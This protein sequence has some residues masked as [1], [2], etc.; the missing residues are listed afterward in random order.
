MEWLNKL[1]TLSNGTQWV[2]MQH[3]EYNGKLYVLVN[4]VINGTQLGKNKVLFR[5][6]DPYGNP[7][8]ED[9]ENSWTKA[10]VFWKMSKEC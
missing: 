5:V 6:E 8:F 9:E 7:R 4:D 1:I 10:K 3:T 2:V